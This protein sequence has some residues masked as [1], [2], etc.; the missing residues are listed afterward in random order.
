MVRMAVLRIESLLLKSTFS[1][2]VSAVTSTECD[3]DVFAWSPY[4]PITHIHLSFASS[5]YHVPF[6]VPVGTFK[7]ILVITQ[8]ETEL[9]SEDT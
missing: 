1:N 2:S 5:R 6:F 7:D 9:T 8:G 3:S 4:F